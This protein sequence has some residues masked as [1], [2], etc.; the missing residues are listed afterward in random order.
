MA[1]AQLEVAYTSVLGILVMSKTKLDTITASVRDFQQESYHQT[2][3]EHDGS[4][5]STVRKLFALP[6]PHYDEQTDLCR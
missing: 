6:L 5:F 4:F 2:S 1:G 3:K